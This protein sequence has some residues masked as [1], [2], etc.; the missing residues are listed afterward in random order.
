MYL[1][2]PRT[3]QTSQNDPKQPLKN[4][5]TIQNDPKFQNWG[6]LEPSYSNWIFWV[7]KYQRSNL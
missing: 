4:H 7:E 2:K 6:N 5:R 3:S 1:L